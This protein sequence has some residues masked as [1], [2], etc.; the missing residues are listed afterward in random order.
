MKFTDEQRL[1]IASNVLSVEER[2]LGYFI[3]R[4]FTIKGGLKIEL[5]CRDLEPPRVVT[6]YINGDH[7]MMVDEHL[8]KMLMKDKIETYKEK[9]KEESLVRSLLLS[10]VLE[11][12]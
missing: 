8:P 6:V 7:F 4:T 1:K 9:L 5:L 2:E 12:L 10:K 11:E 3:T